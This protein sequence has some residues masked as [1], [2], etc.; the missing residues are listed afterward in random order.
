MVHFKRNFFD[1]C[2]FFNLREERHIVEQ[3]KDE[4]YD[5][6]VKFVKVYWRFFYITASL[7]HGVFCSL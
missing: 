5:F 1:Q 4:E 2:F 6:A 3:F 7:I